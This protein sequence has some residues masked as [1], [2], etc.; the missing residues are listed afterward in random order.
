MTALLVNVPT[1][2]RAVVLVALLATLTACGGTA[3]ISGFPVAAAGASTTQLPKTTAE[4]GPTTRVPTSKVG[5]V[6]DTIP[7]DGLIAAGTVTLESAVRQAPG[8]ARLPQPTSGSWLIVNVVIKVSK[9]NAGLPLLASFFE[10]TLRDNSG[11]ANKDASGATGQHSGQGRQARGAGA[12]G[13]G[14]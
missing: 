12:R 14:V 10:F 1:G 3:R 6:G 9:E 5:K 8:P 11:R 2:S 7:Y 13:T 4:A